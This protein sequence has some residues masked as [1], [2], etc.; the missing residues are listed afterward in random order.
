[1]AAVHLSDAL[2]HRLEG[3]ATG[4]LTEVHWPSTAELSE[5]V[6][7]PPSSSVLRGTFQALEAPVFIPTLRASRGQ[8]ESGHGKEQ[9][10]GSIAVGRREGQDREEEL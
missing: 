3:I 8:H 2:H 10:G 6:A 7:K 9:I 5:V 4:H 1:M